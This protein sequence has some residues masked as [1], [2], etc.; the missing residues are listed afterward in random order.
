M[1]NHAAFPQRSYH[2]I[3]LAVPALVEHAWVVRDAGGERELLLPDGRGLLHLV[4]GEPGTVVDALTGARRT[5]GDGVRGPA[6]HV[7]VRDQ[8][9]PAVRLG[10][11]LHPL[12]MSALRAGAPAARLV[13]HEHGV[14]EL[15]PDAVTEHA[16]TALGAGDDERAARLVVEA[17]VA[18]A[19]SGAAGQPSGVDTGPDRDRTTF[20]E[21]VAHVDAERGLVAPGDLARAQGVTVSDLHRW[22]VRYLGV[23]PEAYLAA[24]R[25]TGFVRQAVGPGPVT[26]ADTLAALRWYAQAGQPPRE[27]ERF[28]GLT[29]VELR[30]VEERVEA[31]VPSGV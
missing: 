9:G 2:R 10:V 1:S 17:L 15:L 27:V 29:P 11:Q 7:A 30:R 28:T 8:P 13:A 26:P 4:V 31:L 25:F 22:S 16:R 6:T 23:P 21:V 24:V 19:R 12:A 14:R 3:E 5:D 18:A 20:A